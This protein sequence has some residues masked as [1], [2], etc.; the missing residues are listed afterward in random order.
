MLDS[1]KLTYGKGKMI[2][3]P[4]ESEDY[5]W[6]LWERALKKGNL[7]LRET[8]I[9][10]N[11]D[12]LNWSREEVLSCW[13]EKGTEKL[14]EKWLKD[15]PSTEEE[16]EAHYNNLDLYIPELSSWH[17][18]EKN[19]TLLKIVEFMDLCREKNCKKFLD[20]GSG[21]GSA[22]ILFNYYGFST[23]LADISDAMLNY[24][25]WRF[26]EHRRKSVFVDLKKESLVDNN[27]DCAISIEVL[28]HVSDPVKIMKNIY[29]SLKSGGYLFVT[30]PFFED[31]E[32]PQHLIH[33]P[34]IIKE[35]NKIGLKALSI[36]NEDIYRLYRKDY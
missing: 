31:E 4:E 27:Y 9:K 23:T 15:N 18:I 5:L 11:I 8:L 2:N 35:F 7:S 14:K 28:E 6:E 30:T 10:E 21:I 32:R 3:R 26:K 24:S 19:S 13:G 17:A 1:K 34:S 36:G 29:K 22:G 33:D 12:Y 16:V 20:Y 25:K